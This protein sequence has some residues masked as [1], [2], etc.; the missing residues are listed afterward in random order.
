MLRVAVNPPESLLGQ[1]QE[2]KR[3]LLR[4][5]RR[6]L[7]EDPSVELVLI[8]DQ[9]EEI[10]TLVPDE[11]IRSHFLESLVT[12][13]IDSRS[14]LRVVVTFRADFLDQPL[15]YIDFGEL[16]RQQTE[17]VLPLTPDELE[18]AIIAPARQVGLTFE[19]GLVSRIIREIGDQP[20]G[21]PLLQYTLTELFE[22][23]EGNQLTK[24]AYDLSGRLP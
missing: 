7:P 22:R 10:F 19:P 12:A 4:A 5:V 18:M 14:R 9:F 20:G 13:V 24:A 16:I 6:I 17:M 23:R 11:V 2:S 21:L 3:G 1:L 15:R 8:I